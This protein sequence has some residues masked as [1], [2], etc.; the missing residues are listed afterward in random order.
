MEKVFD[1]IKKLNEALAHEKLDRTSYKKQLQ[2]KLATFRK[3]YRL[4]VPK[5]TE[6]SGFDV[7]Q[8]S[9]TNRSLLFEYEGRPGNSNKSLF[10]EILG[11]KNMAPLIHVI[12]DEFEL[13]RKEIILTTVTVQEILISCF[14][15]IKSIFLDESR[16]KTSYQVRN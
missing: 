2:A 1:E 7:L 5:T 8:T 14:L 10:E 13:W 12:W 15:Y 11:T 9:S 3:L 4:T 6:E 16:R